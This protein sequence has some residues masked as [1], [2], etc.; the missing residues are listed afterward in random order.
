M[1]TAASVNTERYV[2]AHFK[3]GVDKSIAAIYVADRNISKEPMRTI[4]M[5]LFNNRLTRFLRGKG[6]SDGGIVGEPKNKASV[7]VPIPMI[8]GRLT[9]G[10]STRLFEAMERVKADPLSSEVSPKI[11]WD[12]PHDEVVRNRVNDVT[13][14]SQ[15][16][17]MLL[18]EHLSGKPEALIST[19]SKTINNDLLNVS[20]R[21]KVI[22]EV[23]IEYQAEFETLTKIKMSL[24]SAAESIIRATPV[25][26]VNSDDDSTIEDDN[27]AHALAKELNLTDIA[28]E[29]NPAP[30]KETTWPSKV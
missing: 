1:K 23:I 10:Q 26:S 24:I 6:Y 3:R 11:K 9:D 29:T 14:S 25:M 30:R 27:L 7:G 5:A 22:S 21:M 4:T 8:T 15:K 20:D 13:R 2:H 28:G 19:Y 16:R 17:G 12:D 18:P